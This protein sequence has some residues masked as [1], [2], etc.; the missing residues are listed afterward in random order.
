MSTFC[1]LGLPQLAP[2]WPGS[3]RTWPR[4]AAG[5]RLRAPDRF[6]CGEHRCGHGVRC[7][8]VL[9]AVAGTRARARVPSLAH[10]IL[11][12][13]ARVHVSMEHG[14]WRSTRACAVPGICR[15]L[16]GARVCCLRGG[17]QASGR[18][19]VFYRNR[20]RHPR[21]RGIGRQDGQARGGVLGH[22]ACCLSIARAGC[23][24][25]WR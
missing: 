23:H 5:H 19:G 7:V 15:P 11:G 16:D 13:G 3:S 21:C 2:R 17:A 4:R 1:S 14:A 24:R 12:H 9:A 10:R 8:R 22:G 20:A 18:H 25:L 6:E